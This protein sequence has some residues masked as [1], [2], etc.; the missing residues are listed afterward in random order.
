MDPTPLSRL[1][2]D[3]SIFRNA[4]AA[5]EAS[6]SR[7]RWHPKITLYRFL[8]ISTTISLKSEKAVETFYGKS[9]VSTTIEWIAGVA[10]F[11]L[12]SWFISMHLLAWLVDCDLIRLIWSPKYTSEERQRAEGAFPLITTYRLLVSGS[13]FMF[14]MMKA[15]LSYVGLEGAANVLD[16]I[17]GVV[18]TS[19]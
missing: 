5:A 15:Y 10:V 8:V 18:V 2:G 19:M 13:V 17:F 11:T 14:G 16:W 6:N 1:F 7:S 12:L 3:I 9:Y 4:P